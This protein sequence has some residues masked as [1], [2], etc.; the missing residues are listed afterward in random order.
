MDDISYL[1]QRAELMGWGAASAARCLRLQK[2][3]KS[4][5][6]AIEKRAGNIRP[7]V[8]NE[9]TMRPKLYA[10]VFGGTGLSEQFT[11]KIWWAELL[12]TCCR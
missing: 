1:S 7:Q 3:R 4:E 8:V 6:K 5:K 12:Y 2:R 9:W 10:R 11:M